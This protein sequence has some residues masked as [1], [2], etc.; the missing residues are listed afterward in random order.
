MIAMEILTLILYQHDCLETKK[1]FLQY[2]RL[3][4]L[5]KVCVHIA[6][7]CSSKFSPSYTYYTINR[8]FPNLLK[9]DEDRDLISDR[10]FGIFFLFQIMFVRIP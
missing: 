5:A 9:N 4:R 6:I 3:V 8:E 10:F 2:S 1:F 7:R